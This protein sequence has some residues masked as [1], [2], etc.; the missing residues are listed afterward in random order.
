ME[1]DYSSDVSMFVGGGNNQQAMQQ[2]QQMQQQ[3]MMMPPPSMQGGQQMSPMFNYV[4]QTMPPT[5]NVNH[6]FNP[7]ENFGSNFNTKENILSVLV[8]VVLFA[9]FASQPL[10]QF[11]SGL[12]FAGMSPGGDYPFVILLAVGLVFAIIYNVIKL[13]LF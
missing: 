13:F 2:Q 12:P 1:D 3:Q 11:I 8:I 5:A 6:Y 7:M 4:P 9:I 10:K